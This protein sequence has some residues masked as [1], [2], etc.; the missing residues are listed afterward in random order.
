MIPP[1]EI[2]KG[3]DKGFKIC[4]NV[5]ISKVVFGHPAYFY[6]TLCIMIR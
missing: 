1:R 6:F 5:C 4:Y 2:K 3:I